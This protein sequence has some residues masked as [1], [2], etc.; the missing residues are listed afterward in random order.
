MTRKHRI[1]KY[2]SILYRMGQPYF[3][4][5]LNGYNI[6]GGQQFFLLCIADKP[7][8]N[9]M[10]L[11]TDG[12]YDKGTAARAVKKLV[13]EGYVRLEENK[14]DRRIHHLYLTDKARP[15]LEETKRA[16]LKWEEI[17]TADLSETE[18]DMALYLLQ[19]MAYSAFQHTEKE[20]KRM[21]YGTDENTKRDSP[22]L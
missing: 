22:G 15:V 13:Q 4:R 11:A 2:I 1:N 17:V 16:L 18:K 14:V 7:G 8:I 20:R 19:K 12:S 21:K 10:E 5:M 9:V 3:D 6:G